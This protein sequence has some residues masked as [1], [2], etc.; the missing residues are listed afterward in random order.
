[1][2]SS[3][4]FL[5]T[6]VGDVSSKGEVKVGQ[7]SVIPLKTTLCGL[8]R[9]EEQFKNKKYEIVLDEQKKG[10]SDAAKIF[11]QLKRGN[12]TLLDLEIRYK[13]AFTPQP[14]FQGTLNYQFKNL[15]EKECG[16]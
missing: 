1:M 12:I 5:V 16:F 6:G 9:I 8:T 4:L 14:Q 10:S 2:C 3:D 13:G 15:L 7:A 11:L